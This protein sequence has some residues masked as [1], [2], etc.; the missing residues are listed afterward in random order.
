[1]AT[2]LSHSVLN[3]SEEVVDNPCGFCLSSDNKMI[4]ST[5]YCVDCGY[6]ICKSC[7]QAHRKFP[8][9]AGHQIVSVTSTTFGGGRPVPQIPTQRCEEHHGKLLDKYCVDHNQVGCDSC[10]A[11]YHM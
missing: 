3:A 7:T 6:N 10:A 11:I 2:G 1:M 8:M 9:M 4:E 5:H